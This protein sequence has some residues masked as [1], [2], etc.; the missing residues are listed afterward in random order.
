MPKWIF[1][2][3]KNFAKN[4]MATVFTKCKKMNV[5]FVIFYVF[6]DIIKKSV[7]YACKMDI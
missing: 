7:S 5:R 1:D 2:T 4:K 3:F 6:I